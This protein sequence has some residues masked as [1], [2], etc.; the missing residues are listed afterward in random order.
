M[1][2]YKIE[3]FTDSFI[4]LEDQKLN[5]QPKRSATKECSVSPVAIKLLT[6]LTICDC[7]P[8][9]ETT[10]TNTNFGI[11]YF[12]SNFISFL[13]YT[14][15]S[16]YVVC[17]NVMSKP[18]I[19]QKWMILNNVVEQSRIRRK[20]KRNGVY[21]FLCWNQVF[22]SKMCIRDFCQSFGRCTCISENVCV[23]MS[24]WESCT[25]M[26]HTRSPDPHTVCTRRKSTSVSLW[27]MPL[28]SLFIDK[29]GFWS[30]FL[31]ADKPRD[32]FALK[33]I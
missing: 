26:Q 10:T 17:T 29:Y 7:A 16:I 2:Q 11:R 3:C 27:L 1:T 25:H 13:T 24:I 31:L 20:H 9:E 30:A 6:G 32:E 22:G 8:Y 14:R 28:F 5:V 19:E 33:M 15:K 18:T 23:C 12:R 21:F 4:P